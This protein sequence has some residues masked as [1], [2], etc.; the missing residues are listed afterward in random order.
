MILASK[1]PGN[2]EKLSPD[3]SV[4]LYL[5][6]LAKYPTILLE[7]PF[8]QDDWDSWTEFN[9]TCPIELVGDDLLATNI[10]RIKTAEE[11]K[12]CNALLL[13][14]NQIG[15]ISEAINAAK[16]AYD[17]GWSAFVSHRSG[18]TTDDFIADLT[19]ALGSGHLR[20]GSPCRGERVAKY[21]RLMDIEDEITAGGKKV[22]YAGTKGW[23]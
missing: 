8:G 20:T 15:T 12:A 13:K 22:A 23:R 2:P 19:V 6:L 7:G 9:K 16:Y 21:N 10:V 1:I 11:K 5:E 18:E 14:I 17:L 3:E 4:K